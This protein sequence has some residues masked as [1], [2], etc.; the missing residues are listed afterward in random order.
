VG[1]TRDCNKNTPS[2]ALVCESVLDILWDEYC[3]LLVWLLYR[4]DLSGTNGL[5]SLPLTRLFRIPSPFSSLG[6]IAYVA[7][8]VAFL[9]E[10]PPSVPFTA[11]AITSKR[12]ALKKKTR[13]CTLLL[14]R[15]NG[16]EKGGGRGGVYVCVSSTDP[17]ATSAD[18]SSPT[19]AVLFTFS[20]SS[21]TK[22]EAKDANSDHT[23]V[24]L[25]HP[26]HIPKINSYNNTSFRCC[27]H[28][29][30]PAASPLPGNPNCTPLKTR[31]SHGRSMGDLTNTKEIDAPRSSTNNNNN[32][33]IR[34]EGGGGQRPSQKKKKNC[35]CLS[36]SF[37]PPK[38]KTRWTISAT[39]RK[40]AERETP[41]DKQKQHKKRKRAA[42]KA[43]RLRGTS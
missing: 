7:P 35:K 20:A 28:R 16:D 24:H 21:Q 43:K 31:E 10:Q 6:D 36:I 18:E 5:F 40:P 14:S 8:R 27:L 13:V 30:A 23:R 2:A 22:D 3:E 32:E 15:E 39:H 4:Y 37:P 11:S 17:W 33:I 26:I 9:R 25:H 29:N 1:S 42:I 41:Q 38:I 19:G 12:K 34:G